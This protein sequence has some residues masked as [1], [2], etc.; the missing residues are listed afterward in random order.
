MC[1]IA[2][3]IGHIDPLILEA[4]ER[5]S[6]RQAHRGPDDEGFWSS[7]PGR[8]SGI[9][10]AF[11][12]RRLAILDLSPAGHQP[13]I[14]AETGNVIVYNGEVYN[15]RELRAELQQQ[16][17]GCT[18][19]CDTEVILKAYR[20]WGEACVEKFRGMFAFAIWDDAKQSV[21]L[22]RDRVGIKPLYIAEVGEGDLR[23]VLFASELRALLETGLIERTIDPVGLATFLWNGFVIG[24]R[25]IVRGVRLLPAGAAVTI[26]AEHGLAGS[27][28]RRFWSLPMVAD[29]ETRPEEVVQ[30]LREAVRLRLVS[31][32]P[33]GVFLSGGVDSSVV[34]ALA[35]QAADSPIRTFNISFDEQQ[36]DESPFAA[37]VARALGADHTD[38][39]LTRTMFRNNLDD[40]LGAMDQP[41]FD[42]INTYFVSRA[43]REA[44]ITVALAGVGGDELFGGYESFGRVPRAA[45]LS[46]FL[47][48]APGS[49]MMPCAG[50][51]ARARMRNFGAPGPQTSWG[52]LPDVVSARGDLLATYQ[53]SYAMFTRRFLDQIAPGGA[54]AD[55]RWGLPADRAQELRAL[56]HDRS[57][58]RAVSALEV[59]CFVTERLLRDIDCTSMATSLEVRVP[60]LDHEFIA[61]AAGLS[62]VERFLPL[63]RKILLRSIAR[64]AAGSAMVDRPKSGFVIPLDLWCREALRREVEDVLRDEALI[65]SVGLSPAAVEQL[66]NAFCSGHRGIYWSRIWA[67]FVLLWWCREHGM[68]GE[69]GARR[70]VGVRIGTA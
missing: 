64:R 4:V 13:M 14:D 12:H 34:A 30:V 8:G 65:A 50:L 18:S 52:K 47:S 40:A 49:L 54:P 41:S 7:L 32:V 48:M 66:W 5:A 15:F 38:V 28:P 21:F 2:G 43:V 51:V 37:G 61:A 17:I 53:I 67:L 29:R 59:S 1:G 63:K 23:T 10:A 44:G 39:R 9:G 60:L 26:D 3:A 46:R 11:A 27:P 57:D 42:G 56:I 45:R 36:Y 31:D 6:L 16:G 24:P 20:A 19:D 58:L 33:L 69:G 55:V 35:A 68:A 22:A 62:E 25:T 70:P